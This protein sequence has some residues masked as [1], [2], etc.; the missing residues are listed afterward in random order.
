MAL[1][2][3]SKFRGLFIG[4]TLLGASQI[5]LAG[6]TVDQ[7]SNCLMKSTTATDK[8]VVLQWTFVALGNHP[9][10]KA[11]SNV[12]ATQ[13]EA[14]DK[15]LATVLQR[16]LVEQCSAQTKAVIQTEGLQAVGDSFQEL[17]SIT[18]EEILKT[19]EIKQQLNGVLKYVDLNKLVTTF[20]TPDLWNKLG[21][22][23]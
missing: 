22:T 23:R 1:I 12:T 2:S 5:A 3:L 6:P 21:V 15:N 4:A 10:L 14:L 17:G 9:D 20:L 7:L 11:F 16:I 13:K 18:G 19:P 8:T